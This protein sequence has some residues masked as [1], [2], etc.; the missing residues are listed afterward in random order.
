MIQKE[1]EPEKVVI[2]KERRTVKWIEEPQED[3]EIEI[4]KEL[5]KKAI[6]E[7]TVVTRW[8]VPLHEYEAHVRQGAMEA[9]EFEKQDLGY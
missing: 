3:I 9:Y 8:E 1:E 7:E 4:E 5:Q 6:V 2:K